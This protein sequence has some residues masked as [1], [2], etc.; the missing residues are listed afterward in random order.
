MALP[1]P[2]PADLSRDRLAP[3]LDLYRALGGRAASPQLRP[4][5]WDLAFRGGL[6]VELDEELHFNRYRRLTLEPSWAASLPWRQEYLVYT[7]QHE[8]ECFAAARGGKRWT[9]A[10]CEAM[11][12][13]ADPPGM[14]GTRGA[15][16]W[17]QRALCEAMKDAVAL[18]HSEM[19][20]ARLATVDRVGHGDLAAGLEGRFPIDPNALGR[21]FAQRS[22]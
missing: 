6:V 3:I 22:T 14:F 18:D 15:P 16:R 10:S 9:N 17:K 21:L 13:T 20:V 1:S 19:R 7:V 11:F 8:T 2:G 12:W 5:A 4:G